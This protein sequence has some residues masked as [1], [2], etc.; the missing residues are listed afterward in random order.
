MY[1][2]VSVSTDMLE[3]IAPPEYDLEYTDLRDRSS[4]WMGN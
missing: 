3:R 2:P 1:A 4:T